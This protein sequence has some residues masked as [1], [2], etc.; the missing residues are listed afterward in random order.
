MTH[1]LGYDKHAVSGNNSGNSRNETS[2]KTFKTPKRRK[3]QALLDFNHSGTVIPVRAVVWG[4][5]EP[6]LPRAS[7]NLPPAVPESVPATGVTEVDY[8][9]SQS[10]AV[11]VPQAMPIV[12]GL[13]R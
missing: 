11:Q 1:H 7:A 5:P 8:R 10:S 3:F 12:A 4:R 13:I 2:A 6:K 9:V